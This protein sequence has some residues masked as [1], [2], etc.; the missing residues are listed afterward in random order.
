M[1]SKEYVATGEWQRMNATFTL[2]GG[3]Y[4]KVGFQ[5]RTATPGIGIALAIAKPQIQLG[6]VLNGWMTGG[7]NLANNPT[8]ASMLNVF[9]YFSLPLSLDGPN[10]GSRTAR[11]LSIQDSFTNRRESIQCIAQTRNYNY[12]AST[13]WKRLFW[14]AVEA[15]FSGAIEGTVVALNFTRGATWAQL[16]TQT[17]YTLSS[18][19]WGSLSSDNYR[20]TTVR[21][22]SGTGTQRKV[23][24]MLSKAL[25]FKQIYFRIVFNADGTAATSPVR[26]N[27]LMTYVRAKQTV[28]KTVS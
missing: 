6:N 13:V 20:V 23:V 2:N 26:L 22:T 27:S 16:R 14:W 15:T 18:Q 9:G 10:A 1:G 17:W 5:A 19:T 4:G 21:D 12:E 3:P 11:T 28:S 8:F 24:K 25:R 7:Y